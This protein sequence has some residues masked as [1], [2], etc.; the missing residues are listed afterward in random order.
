MK[1][2]YFKK[3]AVA[4]A[5][6]TSFMASPVFAAQVFKST[7]TQPIEGF[8]PIIKSV[9]AQLYLQED[10]TKPY[11]GGTD[12][13]SVTI[14]VGDIVRV[15]THLKEEAYSKFYEVYDLDKDTED[16]KNIVLN[17]EWYL[18]DEGA[19][20][21]DA[22]AKKLGVKD[23]VSGN[24][25]DLGQSYVVGPDAIG[26]QIGFRIK[27]YTQIGLPL[28]GTYLDVPNIAYL[29]GQDYP[30]DEEGNPI[31]D[32]PPVDKPE[33]SNPA[34]EDKPVVPGKQYL[35]QI[36][37]VKT[38]ENLGGQ[39]VFVNRE[40]GARVLVLNEE[41]NSYEDKTDEYKQYITWNLYY[42]DSN[43]HNK[44]AEYMTAKGYMNVPSD[45]EALK[46]FNPDEAT[47][48]PDASVQARF[49]NQD[50]T[51][52]KTQVN[53]EGTIDALKTQGPNFSDQG[54]NLRVNL[55]LPGQ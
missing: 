53:N 24:P 32:L 39:K 13:P 40:Y 19:T 45:E 29:G 4:L 50:N 35:V 33:E 41:S 25:N 7:Y 12:K 38:Q 52:F 49:V 37:D 48:Q 23:G 15:P 34:I 47:Y 8:P 5:V 22:S 14:R 20:K 30:V 43:G 6:F 1:R 51:V 26:K 17:F 36:F 31:P 44:R 2:N 54:L 16:K 46:D 42:T 21:I 10:P 55:V 28:E 18:L 27:P 11:E 3:T 9:G